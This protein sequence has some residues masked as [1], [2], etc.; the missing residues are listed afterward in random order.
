M[1]GAVLL[2]AAL[3]AVGPS[4]AQAAGSGNSTNDILLALA[5]DR[6]AAS[7]ANSIGHGCVGISAFPMG[8]TRTGAAKGFAYWSVRCKDGRS[9]AIQINPAGQAIAIDCQSLQ[10]TGR[11]C[12]KK[13]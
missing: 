4:R 11:E 1:W 9:F 8:V 5:P 6:Q 12:F 7:L 2:L 3:T 10:A 13:F